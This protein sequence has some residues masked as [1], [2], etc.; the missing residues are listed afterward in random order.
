MWLKQISFAQAVLSQKGSAA[1]SFKIWPVVM[2]ELLKFLDSIN[3][4]LFTSLGILRAL[5]IMI[6]LVGHLFCLVGLH[7]FDITMGV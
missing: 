2:T 6:C 5:L 4:E 3:Q 1:S 7:Q